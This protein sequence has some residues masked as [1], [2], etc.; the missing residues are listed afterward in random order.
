MAIK[1]LRKTTMAGLFFIAALFLMM[2]VRYYYT[3]HMPESVEAGS[4]RIIAV[5]VNY[6]RIVYV[7]STERNILYTTYIVSALSGIVAVAAYVMT[8][9]RRDTRGIKN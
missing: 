3:W 1:L 6:G 2:S 4:G 8:R 5:Q 7:D 9:T